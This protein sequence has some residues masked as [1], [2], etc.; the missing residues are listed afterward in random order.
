MSGVGRIS[1]WVWAVAGLAAGV[2]LAVAAVS[3][4]TSD[5]QAW[6]QLARAFLAGENFYATQLHNWPVLWIYFAVAAELVHD[7]TQIS[8]PFLVKLGPVVADASIAWMLARREVRLGLAYALNPVSILITGYHGQ[9]D[10][11]MLAPTVLGWSIWESRRKRLGEASTG[12]LVATALALGVGIWFKP[13][14]LVLL[15]VFLLRIRSNAERVLF[16]VLA[17][18]PATIGTL[19]Y[20]LRWPQDVAANFLGYSSWFG[21]WGYPVVWMI[22]EYVRHGIIPWWLPDPDHVSLALRV[23]FAAGRWV[24]LAALGFTWWWTYRRRATVLHS[25]VTTF[26]AF[27]TATAGFGVQYLLWI[28]P[29]AVLARERWLWAFTVAATGLLIVAYSVGLAYRVVE[30]IPDNGPNLTEFWVKL[31]SLPTWV[32]CGLWTWSLLRRAGRG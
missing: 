6:D 14:P 29:F 20:F 24:L 19:P 9:F 31:A 26:A 2:R 18:A 25:I 16:V 22:E 30:S 12:R 7:A 28:I 15:P 10:A 1:G 3:Y 27:Y 32:V 23:L 4:G 5:V 21:Q 8:F 13:V 11:L 17:I